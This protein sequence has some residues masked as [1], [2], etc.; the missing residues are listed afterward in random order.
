MSLDEMDAKYLTD[1]LSLIKVNIDNIKQIKNLAILKKILNKIFFTDIKSNFHVAE[2]LGNAYVKRYSVEPE[3]YKNIP[4]SYIIEPKK[5][6]AFYG[7]LYKKV[8]K[9]G[10]ETQEF[11]EYSFNS[12]ARFLIDLVSQKVI[13]SKLLDQ[14]V[15]VESFTYT[16]INQ[17]NFN[18]YY[19]VHRNSKLFID[20]FL[21]M[22][23][24]VYSDYIGERHNYNVFNTSLAGKDWKF[25]C[26]TLEMGNTLPRE[27]ELYFTYYE[28]SKSELNL[29][30]ADDMFKK[31]MNEKES[32]NNIRLLHAYILLRKMKL[33]PAEKWFLLKDFGRTGKGLLLKTLYNIFKVNPVNMDALVNNQGASTENAWLSF[34]G[35]DVA[36]ANESGAIDIKAMRVLRK[37]ATGE[38]ITGR[39]LGNNAVT[40]KNESVLVLDTNENVDIGSITANTSRTVKIAFKDRPP[41]ETTQER[42]EFFKPYWDFI[43][44]DNELSDIASIS[45]LI[46][47]LNYLRDIG[48]EFKFKDTVLKNYSSA[49]DFTET[50]RL[51]I[52]TVARHGFVLAGDEDLKKAISEDYGNLRYKEAKDDMKKIGIAINKQKWIEGSNLK[53]HKIKDKKLFNVSLKM[54][55]EENQRLNP[56]S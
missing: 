52:L 28:V 1:E 51:I 17:E 40:F 53:V 31:I 24:E 55:E 32:L 50:Q 12:Y 54:L 27:N 7:S 56:N 14:F 49:D 6:G 46:N 4:L 30:F 39:S 47:S 5:T 3:T 9:E 29:K 36:H 44:P 20:D 11:K 48:G 19:Q 41:G 13:Y 25:D 42:H 15:I 2:N 45:F 35:A 22:M 43:E 8:D 33:I 37:I 16:V 34:K 18:D 38:I 23:L 10:M 21:D 26:K